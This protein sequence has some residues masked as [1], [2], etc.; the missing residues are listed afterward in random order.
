MKKASALLPLSVASA[1]AC[2]CASLRLA[3]TGAMMSWILVGVG[4]GS[5]GVR[6][7]WDGKVTVMGGWVVVGGGG[8][9]HHV[10]MRSSKKPARSTTKASSM[11]VVLCGLVL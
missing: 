8:R 6:V 3:S 11:C 2:A 9:G 5:G 4:W 1:C 10:R 7:G